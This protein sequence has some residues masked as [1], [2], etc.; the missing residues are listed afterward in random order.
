MSR[1]LRIEYPG[2]LYHVTSRGNVRDSIYLSDQDRERFLQMWQEEVEHQGWVCYAYCMMD[3]HYHLL[4]ETPEGDLS[5]GMQRLN[6]RYTQYFNHAHHRVGHLFQG[7]YKAILVEKEAHL[8]EL[9]RYVVLN[10]VRARMVNAAGDWPWSSYRA[11]CEGGQDSWL[12]VQSVLSLFGVSG[13]QSVDHYKRFVED[14]VHIGG[15]WK[16]LRG[17]IY[18][19]SDSF[20]DDMQCRID[21]HVL[22]RDISFEQRHPSR[23]SVD[24][25]IEAVM[26]HYNMDRAGVL[27]KRNKKPFRLVVFL[28]RRVCNAP[29][30]EVAVLTGV[31]EG[32]VS[33]I[34]HAML[35]AERDHEMSE[36][37]EK[38]N[39]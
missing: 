10:P 12:A 34:H 38:F 31:S 6:G 22:D 21:K 24:V 29:L 13:Q 7:R 19:G 9:C 30:R 33:Q 25:V 5:R 36:F 15:P 14:G 39:V 18:L 37:V 8:L 3:N 26:R 23:A 35:K 2:A 20:V 4:F 16:Q 32:R 1:P 11:M 17:Q 27:D 28:L